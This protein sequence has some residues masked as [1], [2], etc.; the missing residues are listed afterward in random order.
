M[1][2][3]RSNTYNDDNSREHYKID[4]S[5]S[6]K[7]QSTTLV[8]S[9]SLDTVYFGE[10]KIG[11]QKFDILFDT[12]SSN[13]FV[14]DKNCISASCFNHN[15]F[16]PNKSPTFKKEGNPW[17]IVFGTGFASGITGIDDVTLAGFTAKKQIFGLAT[18][19]SDFFVPLVAD[20]ILGLA[21]DSLNTLDN[22]S[23]TF[24]STLINQK[25]INPLF[26][27]HLPRAANFEDQ[28]T[29]TLGGVERDKFKGDITFSHVQK[30]PVNGTDKF[31]FWIINLE[32]ASVNKKSLSTKRKAIMDTGTSNI[33]I[34][35]DDAAKLH[36]Q[37]PGAKI[38][39]SGS[40]LFIIPCNTKAVVSLK[41]GGKNFEINPIDLVM[42]VSENLCASA[43]MPGFAPG[44]WLVGIT[45]LKNV[46]SVFDV[47]TPSVGL[48]NNR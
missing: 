15:K 6:K 13:L 1:K 10:I 2:H 9:D 4:K 24:I 7:K 47:K 43:I 22:G 11:N 46:Y 19:V 33:I 30:T 38:D 45:F 35:N 8:K 36:S 41:F 32:D 34:P 23:P 28:G 5:N 42:P 31:G 29:L 12:G 3:A 16:D 37:I 27:F 17:S 18:N 39:P 20:G 14:S 26:S 25:K 44:Y 48:A 21:F 40:G